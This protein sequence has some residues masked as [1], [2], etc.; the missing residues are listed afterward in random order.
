MTGERL[1]QAMQAVDPALVEDAREGRRT[2]RLLRGRKL[3][4]ALAAAALIL[5]LGVGAAA[6]YGDA[7]LDFF[8]RQNGGELTAAQQATIETM[9]TVVGQSQTVDGWTVTVDKALASRYDAYIKLD[10]TGPAGVDASGVE[11]DLQ[12]NSVE[13]FFLNTDETSMEGVTGHGIQMERIEDAAQPENEATIL[14]KLDITA[15]SDSEINLADGQPRTLTLRNL[16][17]S[18]EKGEGRLLVAEGEWSFTFTLPE[19]QEIELLDNTISVMVKEDRHKVDV[20]VSS[21]RLTAF[22]ATCEYITAFD[23]IEHFDD[24]TVTMTDGSAVTGET[25]TNSARDFG[26]VC[27]FRFDVPIDLDAV[28]H[29]IF[30]GVYLPMPDGQ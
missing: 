25:R 30:Q 3:T 9:T 28:D 14:M 15:M 7:F 29:V 5:T 19:A 24:V 21:F 23:Y 10:V 18:G 1:L 13:S 8:A 6:Y 4:A 11:F 12:K 17:L 20:A 27:S 16:Y 26:K 22:G 2:P